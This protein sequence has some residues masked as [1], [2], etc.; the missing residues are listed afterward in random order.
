MMKNLCAVSFLVASLYAGNV[1]AQPAAVKKIIEIGTTD[2]RVMHQLDVLTNRFGGRPI[3]SANLGVGVS[4]LIWKKPVSCL[5]VL[6]VV[7]G[8][9]ALSGATSR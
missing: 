3:G 4:K 9:D 1:Y 6:T 2:N 5:W 7:H 8:S